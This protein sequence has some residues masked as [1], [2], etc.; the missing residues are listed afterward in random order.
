MAKPNTPGKP[1]MKQTPPPEIEAEHRRL[2]E[3]Y[4]HSLEDE[5]AWG[6]FLPSRSGQ[7]FLA[8]LKKERNDAARGWQSVAPKD[9]IATQEAFKAKEMLISRMQGRDGVLERVTDARRA[10][11][12]FEDEN[13]LCGIVPY[14][15][16]RDRREQEAAEE[17]SG[18]VEAAHQADDL[19]E[20]VVAAD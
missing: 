12:R 10:L 13:A 4:D 9:L 2:I 14:V 3:E 1:G 8:N 20:A 5:E 19:D 7:R 6:I 16:Q 18:K 17:A 11:R 15:V